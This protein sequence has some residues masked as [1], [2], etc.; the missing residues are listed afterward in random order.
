MYLLDYLYLCGMV[1]FHL[2]RGIM[3]LHSDGLLCSLETELFV[4]IVPSIHLYV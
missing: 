1:A 2:H 4:A 3:V